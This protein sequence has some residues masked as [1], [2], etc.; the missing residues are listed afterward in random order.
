LLVRLKSGPILISGDTYHFTDQVKN[1]GVPKFNSNR[2]DS[3]ASMDRFDRIAHNLG[4]KVIIQHEPADIAKLP[5][6]PMA[7]E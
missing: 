3:L 4:A 6:F 1:R 2:A 5:A 7:A